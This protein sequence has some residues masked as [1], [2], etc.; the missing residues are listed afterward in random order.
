MDEKR[1]ERLEAG[2]SVWE[3]FSQSLFHKFDVPDTALDNGDK[4]CST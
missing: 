4:V 1:W 2:S 3:L